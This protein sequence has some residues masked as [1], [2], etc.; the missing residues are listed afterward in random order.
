MASEVNSVRENTPAATDNGNVSNDE[1]EEE[2]EDTDNINGTATG[3]SGMV[4][5]DDEEF[6][7]ELQAWRTLTAKS[8]ANYCAKEQI[9]LMKMDILKVMSPLFV[10]NPMK[11]QISTNI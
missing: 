7:P 10:G 5:G 3:I 1:E 8:R 9:Y 6:D 4:D 2:E 11:C